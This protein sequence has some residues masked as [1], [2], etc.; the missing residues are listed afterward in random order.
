VDVLDA[1]SRPQAGVTVEVIASFLDLLE[2]ESV[3]TRFA[4]PDP[5]WRTETGPGGRAVLAGLPARSELALVVRSGREEL[6][7]QEVPY[8]QP[9]EERTLEL[10]LGTGATIV[11]EAVEAGGTPLPDAEVW[12]LEGSGV[13]YLTGPIERTKA[14]TR[15][16]ASGRFRFEKV[17][18]GGWSVG[19]G[20]QEGDVPAEQLLSRVTTPVD[21]ADGDVS[22][23]LVAH[24]GVVVE[25]SVV[26]AAGQGLGGLHVTA[27]S[28]LPEGRLGTRSGEDGSFLIGGLVPGELEL[29]ASAPGAEGAFAP[30]DSVTVQAG[31]RGIVLRVDAAASL[32]G[33]LVAGADGAP[34]DVDL[35]LCR[36]DGALPVE[37]LTMRR[38]RGD[39]FEVGGLRAGVWGIGVTTR[40]GR[41]GVLGGISLAAGQRRD[42]L[43]LRL[44]PG[45]DLRVRDELGE[46]LAGCTISVHA[47]GACLGWNG[48]FPGGTLHF[49]VPGGHLRV[50][51]IRGGRLVREV[52]VD[53][54]AG[55]VAEVVLE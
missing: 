40:D 11:G 50:V 12:L 24:R 15:T 54:L 32:S 7:S 9:G 26:D 55:E 27:R 2:E 36:S 37:D 44:E 1:A 51:A 19:L 13:A 35:L 34:G 23:R 53:V 20:P 28:R 21:V 3:G 4:T 46:A 47:E 10:R 18:T 38:L 6:H 14:R 29:S 49:R 5:R 45:A 16:D 39:T 31:Q 25:G 48:T 43:E 30:S 52:E 8:L 22:V 17:L 41:V 42:G 33:R